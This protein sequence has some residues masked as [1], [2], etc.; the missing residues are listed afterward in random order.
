MMEKLIV[1]LLAIICGCNT[2][3]PSSSLNENQGPNKTIRN[4]KCE[5][6]YSFQV[7]Q[8]L[9][10]YVLANVCDGNS[11]DYCYGHVVYFQRERGKIYF[12]DQRINVKQGECPIY[13][14]TFQYVTR[15]GLVKTVPKVKIVDSEMPN[16]EYGEWLKNKNKK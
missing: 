13:V 15:D 6:I 1:I 16:P 3:K 8:V 9:N 12:D 10:N 4:P 2:I 11:S 14:G 7:F 5:D